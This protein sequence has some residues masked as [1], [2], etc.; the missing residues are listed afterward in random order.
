MAVGL[1]DLDPLQPAGRRFLHEDVAADIAEL[2]GHA[3]AERGQ[4]LGVV[5][6]ATAAVYCSGRMRVAHQADGLAGDV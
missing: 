1:V 6:P 3:L 2:P 4:R 5:A